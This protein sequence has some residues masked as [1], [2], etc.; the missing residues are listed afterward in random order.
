[1]TQR[2]AKRGTLSLRP[3]SA[4]PL[5]FMRAPQNFEVQLG[6]ISWKQ[7]Q[8]SVKSYQRGGALYVSTTT[9]ELDLEGR[10]PAQIHATLYGA[11]E[12]FVNAEWVERISRTF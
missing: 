7:M 11:L 3:Q 10:I 4:A 12:D 9:V 5:R 1:M 2:R 6:L 8:I